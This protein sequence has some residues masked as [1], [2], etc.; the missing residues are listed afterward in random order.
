MG[1]AESL[2]V[3]KAWTKLNLVQEPQKSSGETPAPLEAYLTYWAFSAHQF[4]GYEDQPSFPDIPLDL[5]PK[6]AGGYR[7]AGE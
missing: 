2:G 3:E 1:Q 6:I 7:Q 5:P 4:A